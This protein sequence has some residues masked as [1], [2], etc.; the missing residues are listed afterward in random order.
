MDN[1]IKRLEKR[2][3]NKKEIN[4]ALKIIKKAKQSKTKEGLFLEKRVYWILLA[5]II[6]ANYSISVA[7]MPIL[8]TLKGGIIYAIIIGLGLV[9]GLLFE[10]VIRSIEH[11]N[12]R[13]HIILAILIPLIAFTNIL[14]IS[15]VSNDISQILELKVVQNNFLVGFVYSIFF[16]LPYIIYRFILKI[17]YYSKE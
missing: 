11:L 4:K 8:A 7:L 5:V 2:G 13:H 14:V 1:L 3:W 9:F 15:S 10:L 16:V 6:T 12:K 17:E